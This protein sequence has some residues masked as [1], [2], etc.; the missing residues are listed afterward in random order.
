MINS[1]ATNSVFKFYFYVYRCFFFV[2]V[3]LFCFCIVVRVACVCVFGDHGG[4]KKPSDPQELVKRPNVGAE[5]QNR[6]FWK[7]H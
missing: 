1:S 3:V 7:S 4:Q 2:A 6:V 5:T